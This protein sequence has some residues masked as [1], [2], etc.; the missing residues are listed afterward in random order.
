MALGVVLAGSGYG[1]DLT[2][3]VRCRLLTGALLRLPLRDVVVRDRSTS[4]SEVL[5]A[6]RSRY[7]CTARS[8]GRKLNEMANP[9]DIAR[10]LRGKDVWNDWAANEAAAGRCP[11]VNFDDARIAAGDFAGFVFP[12][13]ASFAR[14]KFQSDANFNS[15]SFC[16][17]AC[18]DFATFCGDV[19]FRATAFGS[20]AEF[21]GVTF[22]RKTKFNGAS[23]ASWANFLSAEFNGAVTDFADVAF[24][25]VP[26]FRQAVFARP[27]DFHRVTIKLV[28]RKAGSLW[29]DLLGG[30][31][32]GEDAPRY[33]QMKQIAAGS[34]DHEREL[35]FFV[36]ELRAKR[37]HETD[38]VGA[39]ALNVIYDWLS[40]YGQSALRPVCWLIG[41]T[42]LATAIIALERWSLPENA[43][44][45]LGA[46]A[47][48]ALTNVSLLIGSDRWLLRTKAFSTL[49]YGEERTFGLLGETLAYGQSALS[50]L[51]FFL[52]GLAL[53]NRFRVGGSG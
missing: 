40:E 7:G 31:A 44:A 2:L 27:P 51:L 5:K 52:I 19:S 45:K 17:E 23:F 36:G 41:L 49:G 20:H 6:A 38:G 43:V 34:K 37:F 35:T 47:V 10:A 15:A 39:I 11:D 1:Y 14:A 53:R 42:S 13:A 50:L 46:S 28:T 32:H 29:K 33:R 21:Y 3:I 9:A 8:W 48:L 22:S 18:F 30:I 4:A 16:K 24:G 26:D 25:W 12:G